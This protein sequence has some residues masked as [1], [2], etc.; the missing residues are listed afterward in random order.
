MSKPQEAP[1]GTW[2]SPLSADIFAAGAVSL[3][4]VVVSVSSQQPNLSVVLAL[5][6]FRQQSNSRIY[7]LEVRPAES[8]RGCIVEIGDDGCSHRDILPKEYNALTHVHE[9][10]GASFAVKSNTGHIIFSDFE[11][12][13]VFDLDPATLTAE[14]IIEEDFQNYY[15]DFNAHPT[16]SR[17]VLAIREDH[18]SSRIEDIENTLVAIDSSTRTVHTIVRGADFYAYP[19]F[20]PDGRRVSWTQWH[21]PNMPWHYNEL[22]V[23]DWQEGKVVNSKVVAG[24]DI[25]ESITQPQWGEDGSLFFVG[26]R[27]SFWQLYQLVDNEVRRVHVKGLE[28]A[29]FGAPEWC[30]GR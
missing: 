9:Y 18:H 30:L 26:D 12:N 27:T 19:R 6:M 15:A 20:S 4:E 21:H 8:G 5:L 1:Y 10:G 16:D 11:S 23:A 14:P 13:L 7:L 22:W 3:K 24:Q 28:E 29:E 2:R 25:K 17:W